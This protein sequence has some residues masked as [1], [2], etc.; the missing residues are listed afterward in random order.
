MKI[1]TRTVDNITILDLHDHLIFA[2]GSA[3]ALGKKIEGLLEVGRKN[4][5]LNVRDVGYVDSSGVGELLGSYTRVME[6]GGQIKLLNV[7]K[8]LHQVLTIAKVIKFFDTYEDEQEA[9]ASFL[10]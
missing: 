7:S 8:R 6:R 2:K 9:V 5:V 1:R 10:A 4:I 3:R